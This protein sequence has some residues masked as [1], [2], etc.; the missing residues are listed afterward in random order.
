[1][2]ASDPKRTFAQISHVRVK[3]CELGRFPGPRNCLG[4]ASRGEGRPAL[5]REHKRRGR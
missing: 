2:S 5:R 3:A 1:M 4:E